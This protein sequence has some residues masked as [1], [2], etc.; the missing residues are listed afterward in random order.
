M[1]FENVVQH[2]TNLA[3]GRKVAAMSPEP[4]PR[5]RLSIYPR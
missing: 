4:N 5:D 2:A 3:I 1:T